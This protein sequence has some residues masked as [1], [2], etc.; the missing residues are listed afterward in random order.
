MNH[1]LYRAVWRWHFSAGLIVLPVL[2]WMAVT[3]A[4]YLYKSEIER[5][6]YQP[7]IELAER[8]PGMPLG[9]L[10]GSVEAQ[11]LGEVKQ[12]RIPEGAH[13]SYRASFERSDGSR[14]LAFVRP[15]TGQVLGIS[16]DGG[17]L[18][19][20]KEL[21]TLSTFGSA[22]NVVVEIVAGWAIILVLS[23]F[24]L[25][26]PRGG[27]GILSLAGKVR[28]RRFWR[29]L[30]AS[31][32]LLAG[33]VILFLAL[34]GMPWTAFWGANFHRIVA[35]QQIG[36]PAPPAAAAAAAS[37]GHEDHLPWSM[38]GQPMP[39]ASAQDSGPQTALIAASAR[40]LKR[41][42]FIDLPATPGQPYRAATEA[43]RAQDARIMYLDPTNG[44]VLQDSRP[45]DFG[46]GA[47]IFDWG[48]YTHQGQQYGE[49]NRLIMLTGCIGALLLAISAPIMWLKRR[50]RG[51][52]DAPPVPSD[53]RIAR[54][55]TIGMLALGL[56]F[57]LTGATM[58]LAVLGQW[59]AQWRRRARRIA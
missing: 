38:Q 46:I 3:G 26:W 16:R 33:G 21:H 8:G 20:V 24:Y 51:R 30:H 40:G 35:E 17:P 1:S 47:R 27:N 9:E 5:S 15:D 19:L 36:R 39:A 37:D 29:N 42:F 55:L 13:E 23:G 34:T 48:I 31:V 10:V 54:R 7:W 43:T 56:L 44:A 52:L 22:A 18:A 59:A 45:A 28:E 25:W 2:A 32:G 12:L 50:R 41:P 57:P 49:I 4:I 6:L 11:T 53:E 14:G 58:L